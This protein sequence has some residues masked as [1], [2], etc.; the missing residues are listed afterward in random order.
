[1]FHPNWSLFLVFI[2]IFALVV[3][4][5]LLCSLLVSASLFVRCPFTARRACTHLTQTHTHT[6]RRITGHIHGE[7]DR[8]ATLGSRFFSPGQAR[9]GY[10][11]HPPTTHFNLQRNCFR[12]FE[13]LKTSREERLLLERGGVF[14]VELTCFAKKGGK[15]IVII[16]VLFFC[17]V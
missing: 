12:C 13:F 10:L 6:L 5:S 3:F 1:M 16:V 2:T 8:Q 11:N 14:V 17:K 15:I 7:A 9:P 4:L